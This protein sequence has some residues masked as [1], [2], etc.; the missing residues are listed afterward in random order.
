LH[1]RSD[2]VLRFPWAPIC[3]GASA[4]KRCGRR[5]AMARYNQHPLLASPA[6]HRWNRLCQTILIGTERSDTELWL[7]ARVRKNLST[8]LNSSG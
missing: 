7:P 6:D 1:Q 4:A 8:P 3:A 2:E 5:L